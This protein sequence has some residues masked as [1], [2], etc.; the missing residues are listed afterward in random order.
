MSKITN[1]S[2]YFV[3]TGLIAYEGNFPSFPSLFL[4]EALPLALLGLLGARGQRH[5][6]PVH[7]PEKHEM[8]PINL[9]GIA[10]INPHLP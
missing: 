6:L 10:K 4:V 3:H 5:T 9:R 2:K 1:F 8:E 7:I